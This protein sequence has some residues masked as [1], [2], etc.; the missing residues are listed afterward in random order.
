MLLCTFGEVGHVLA[1]SFAMG[2]FFIVYTHQTGSADL[3]LGRHRI[4]DVGLEHLLAFHVAQSL[5]NATTSSMDDSVIPLPATLQQQQVKEALHEDS[6]Q[7]SQPV[8]SDSS[9]VLV[10]APQT[11]SVTAVDTQRVHSADLHATPSGQ[12]VVSSAN[13]AT[14]IEPHPHI[15]HLQN[16]D[17]T[18]D[19]NQPE[20]GLAN[21]G[22]AEAEHDPSAIQAPLVK[23]VANEDLFILI[24]RFD[25]TITHLRSIPRVTSV[26]KLDLDD[27]HDQEFSPDK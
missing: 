18:D 4:N 7:P 2:A 24:R 3:L 20:P 17:D 1:I 13:P 11:G 14:S 5:L 21:L 9:T 15:A 22:W 26:R 8:S 16:S 27:S 25:K 6:A 23:G 19:A 12:P 10:E